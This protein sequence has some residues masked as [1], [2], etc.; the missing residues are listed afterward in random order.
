MA[1]VRECDTTFADYVW[2]H[3]KLEEE[4]N[5]MTMYPD[6]DAI[7]DE[8]PQPLNFLHDWASLPYRGKYGG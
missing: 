4:V 3:E 5:I 7:G 8:P 6:P 2:A 1:A